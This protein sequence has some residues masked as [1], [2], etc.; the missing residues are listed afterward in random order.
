[1]GLE[2]ARRQLRLAAR[3]NGFS[4]LPRNAGLAASVHR[5]H[6]IEYAD[7]PD[8]RIWYSRFQLSDMLAS[9]HSELHEAA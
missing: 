2:A 8:P 9:T 5:K 4:P 3:S 6:M 7:M 1:M